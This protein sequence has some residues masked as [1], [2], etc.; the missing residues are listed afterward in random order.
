MTTSRMLSPSTVTTSISLP[1][2]ESALRVEMPLAPACDASVRA[3][4][5]TCGVDMNEESCQCADQPREDGPFAGLKD[6]LETD[7][8]SE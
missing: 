6:L 3:S 8:D 2:V 7:H 1:S 4:A 5:P